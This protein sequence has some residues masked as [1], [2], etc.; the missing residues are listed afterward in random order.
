MDKAQR[1]RSMLGGLLVVVG[2]LGGIGY[3]ALLHDNFGNEILHFRRITLIE[4]SA[5]S[6]PGF[7]EMGRDALRDDLAD[8]GNRPPGVNR[9]GAK[10]AERQSRSGW[11]LPA[12]QDRRKI[13]A[14]CDEFSR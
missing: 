13:F 7:I 2:L 5:Q 11:G 8:A 12:L 10:H 6:A 14:A 3:R 4:K 1:W 9:R